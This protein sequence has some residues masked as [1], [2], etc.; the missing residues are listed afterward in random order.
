MKKFKNSDFTNLIYPNFKKR[1]KIAFKALLKSCMAICM[2]RVSKI[3]F[4]GKFERL[5]A[6]YIER[7]NK[8]CSK[9]KKT[10]F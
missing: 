5:V 9:L 6:F 2:G 8:K 4:K 7:Q 1:S 3:N 10:F